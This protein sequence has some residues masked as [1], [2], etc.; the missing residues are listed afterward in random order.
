MVDKRLV[1][2]LKFVHCGPEEETHSALSVSVCG[3]PTKFV[4]TFF[5]MDQE[6]KFERKEVR[7]AKKV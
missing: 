3:D 7:I 2:N 6:E 5:H 1:C 4:N